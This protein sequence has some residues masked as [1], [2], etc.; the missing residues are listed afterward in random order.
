MPESDRNHCFSNVTV[1]QALI[2]KFVL[3]LRAFQHG[4][5]A[6]T[7]ERGD[8]V[9]RDTDQQHQARA[10]DPHAKLPPLTFPV[11]P[12]LASLNVTMNL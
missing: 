7:S 4:I 1:L 2:P 10:P 8:A 12:I 9:E 6:S 5:S 11:G 3:S